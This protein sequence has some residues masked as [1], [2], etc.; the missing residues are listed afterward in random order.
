MLEQHLQN[1]Q[2]SF[3]GGPLVWRRIELQALRAWEVVWWMPRGVS[4]RRAVDGSL[5]L[6]SRYI[7]RLGV[8]AVAWQVSCMIELFF[9][10]GTAK[11]GRQH[12]L[13][14]DLRFQALQL[15]NGEGQQDCRQKPLVVSIN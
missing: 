9:C 5:V 14:L 8:S 6:C 7:G 10:G 12:V 2:A 13:E 3:L 15:R 11:V 1:V 4:G